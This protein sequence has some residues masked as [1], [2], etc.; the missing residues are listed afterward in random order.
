MPK[1]S[2][3][4]LINRLEVLNPSWSRFGKVDTLSCHKE[5]D[6]VC[7]TSPD[8]SRNYAV[9]LSVSDA[10]TWLDGFEPCMALNTTGGEK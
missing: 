8:Q 3:A 10:H 9:G 5:N 6:A 4:K 7:F 1:K 2:Y